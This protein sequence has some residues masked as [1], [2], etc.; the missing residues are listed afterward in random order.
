[1][2]LAELSEVKYDPTNFFRMNHNIKPTKAAHA[3]T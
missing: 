2:A 3:T 1:V